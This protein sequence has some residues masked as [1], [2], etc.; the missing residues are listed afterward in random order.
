MKEKVFREYIDE[1]KKLPLE[2]RKKLTIDKIKNILVVIDEFIELED[3]NNELLL[4]ADVNKIDSDDEFV[5][6]IY[7]YMNTIQE[8]LAIYLENNINKKGD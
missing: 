6:A 8:S 2:E 7:V 3:L 1:F 5:N 4:T